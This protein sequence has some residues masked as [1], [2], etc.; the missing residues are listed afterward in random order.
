MIFKVTQ[1]DN[2]AKYICWGTFYFFN[3]AEMPADKS[4]KNAVLVYISATNQI[5]GP[6]LQS[7]DEQRNFDPYSKIKYNKIGK[8]IAADLYIFK[9]DQY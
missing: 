9:L 8:L 4:L 5:C 2:C 7:K 1:F 3:D 6:G